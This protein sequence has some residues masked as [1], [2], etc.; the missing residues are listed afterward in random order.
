MRVRD[1]WCVE[2][3]DLWVFAL[4]FLL[5]LWA[6]RGVLVGTHDPFLNSLRDYEPWKSNLTAEDI[7][8]SE[9]FATDPITQTWSWAVYSKENIR[10]GDFPLW[11][12]RMYC[13]TPFVA[14]RL[15]GLFNPLV[16]IPVSL[17]PTIPALILFY[18]AHYLL[19][20]WF[21][22]LFLKCLGL[23]RPAATFGAIAYIFQGAYI[24]WMG[25]I[26]CDKAY[27][28]MTLYYLERICS[29]RDRT[30]IIGYIVSFLLLSITS[31]PQMVVF[32]IYIHAAWVLFVRGGSMGPAVGR[33]IGLTVML[34]LTFL[35]GAMQHL[36]M[37]EFYNSSLR[38]LPEF[39]WELNSP[40]PLEQFDSPISLLAIIFPR[41]WGDYLTDPTGALPTRVLRVYNHAYIGILPAVGFLFASLVWKNRYARFF[42][43]LALVGLIFIAWHE[44]Y[45]FVVKLLPGLRISGIKP[46]FMT[47]TCMII[48]SAFVLDHLLRNLK[49]DPT[50]SRKYSHGFSWIVGALLGLSAVLIGSRVI[51][52]FLTVL[53]F[54]P[55]VSIYVELVILWLAGA[56]LYLYVSR[57]LA[58]K[59]AVV[60]VIALLLI[61]LVPYHEH[62][63]PLIPKGR[64]CFS[65]PSIE[66][67]QDRMRKDGPFRIFRDRH[68]V[69]MPNTPML[70]QLDEI[71]G[72][73]SFVVGDYGMFFMSVDPQMVISSR[74]IEMPGEYDVYRRPFWSFLN[75]R[76]FVSPGP[77]PRL[78]EPWKRVWGGEVYIYENPN[79]LDRWF[80]VDR[81]IPV[82]SIEEGYEK[83]QEIDPARE[84][85]IVTSDPNRLL[86]GL[87]A[88]SGAGRSQERI[89][90]ITL[91]SYGPD[92]LRVTADCER[93]CFL[94]FSDTYF[95]GWR[96]WVDDVEV[97]IYR[98]DA[99]VKGIVVPEGTHRIRFLYDPAS[100]KIGWLLFLVGLALTPFSLRWITGLFDR[101]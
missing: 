64:T 40:S 79:W 27:L 51:P 67:M 81:V 78:P 94:V 16:L 83:A 43:V 8:R 93:D 20:A 60:G 77:M 35:L 49:T 89:G 10:N 66:F 30:G 63:T 99:V 3:A 44:F 98:T 4:L 76:Y 15:T 18:F 58:I 34:V 65:T 7:G 75:V 97:E 85:V 39:E 42:T 14:N 95:N 48:V 29:R 59:W 13:G 90:T 55:F 47:F 50:L 5:V 22:Y 28:P 45:V 84:A 82:E 33:L 32:A 37:F 61:D 41:L 2:R 38:A 26:V 52:G 91:E 9:S 21:M 6:F 70:F 101:S 100:Y 87:L 80:L 25:W 86:P 57:G 54:P 71:S 36:P 31:Y 72:F 1:Q 24:P 62:F 96:A 17:L 68:F 11:N 12:T 92:E 23:S 69:L 19:A 74:H 53:N 73:D 56:L 88:E 46:V